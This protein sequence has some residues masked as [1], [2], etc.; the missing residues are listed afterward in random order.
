MGSTGQIRRT[1]KRGPHAT[2]V[3]ADNLDA[4]LARVEIINMTLPMAFRAG[5]LRTR[6][7]QARLPQRH[8]LWR[9]I[10]RYRRTV[11]GHWPG[12]ADYTHPTPPDRAGATRNHIGK[13]PLR[14]ECGRRLIAIGGR[15]AAGFSIDTLNL[16]VAQYPPC[17]RVSRKPRVPRRSL[18]TVSSI[19]GAPHRLHSIAMSRLR[20]LFSAVTLTEGQNK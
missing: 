2:T 1:A 14:P 19:V 17:E 10:D 3:A 8:G 18:V 7:R 12:I 13:N 11:A 16:Q 15:T 5:L 4:G 20:L 6:P 9:S